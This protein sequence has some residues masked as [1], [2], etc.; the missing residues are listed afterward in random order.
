[1]AEV[2]QSIA[3]TVRIAGDGA[4]EGFALPAYEAPGAAIYD[5]DPHLVARVDQG[6][7]ASAA[8]FRRALVP[9][10]PGRFAPPP[11]KLVTFSP[12]RAAYVTHEL[13]MPAIEVRPGREGT[14]EITSFAPDATPE[15]LLDEVDMAPRPILRSG[16]AQAW[17]LT[18]WLPAALGLTALPA[19]LLWLWELSAV[20]RAWW[21]RRQVPIEVERTASEVV[22]RAPREPKARATAFETALRLAIA[23]RP[24]DQGLQDLYDDFLRARFG[25]ESID[26]DLEVRIERAVRTHGEDA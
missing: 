19:L 1:Q 4:L 23:E 24:D 8:T 21:D 15:E 6:R 7:Y 12:S 13:D 18:G 16:R 2:G 10:E 9:T 17:R 3:W 20:G 26:R 25:D 14:G 5:K 11:M 22:A